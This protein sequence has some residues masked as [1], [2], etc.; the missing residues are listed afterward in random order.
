MRPWKIWG[1]DVSKQVFGQLTQHMFNLLVAMKIGQN[2]SLE[3]EWY[4]INIVSDCCLGVFIQYIYLNI[5]TY[6]LKDCGEY[7]LNSGD[8]G[9]NG[10][11]NKY[12]YQLVIWLLIV[13]MV[14]KAINLE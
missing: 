5:I 14:N 4:L 12:L 7:S 6:S 13:T 2:L 11:C 9:N 3:C 10:N 1:Y 8:Y